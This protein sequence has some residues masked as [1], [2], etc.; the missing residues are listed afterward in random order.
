MKQTDDRELIPISAYRVVGGPN[1]GLMQVSPV[2]HNK[3]MEIYNKMR[4]DHWHESEVN[5]SQDVH[6]WN[7]LT[8]SE[9]KAYRKALAFLSNLDGMQL[10]N[11]K[12]I[13]KELT[14]PW[15]EMA[16]SRQRFDESLHVLAYSLMIETMG[17]DAVETYNMFLTDDLL[18][19]KN[20]F[21]RDMNEQVGSGDKIENFILATVA[22]QALEGIMFQSGFLLFYVLSE[23]GKMHNSAKQ[24]KFIQRDELNHLRLFFAMFEDL[25]Q[26]NPEYFTEELIQKARAILKNAAEMEIKWGQYII[27]DGIMGLNDETVEK[28]IKHLADYFSE[29]LGLGLLFG[30]GEITPNPCSWMDARMSDFGIDTDFFQDKVDSYDAASEW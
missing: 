23:A 14:S 25:R 13:Q 28:Y 15:Y 27:S 29:G 11:L 20:Q 3:A 4:D 16:I 12:V 10:Y 26:E 19:A 18:Y 7:T 2:K 9:Q 6:S 5:M 30:E 22:N 24:V 1:N 21:V 8:E 17:F